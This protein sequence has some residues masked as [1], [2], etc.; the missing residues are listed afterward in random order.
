MSESIITLTAS[1]GE[2]VQFRDKIIA[3]GG[4]K[5]VYAS[6]DKTYV[7][8][9]YR[10]ELDDASRQRL[11]MITGPYR[12]R[13]FSEASGDYWHQMFCWPTATVEHEAVSVWWRHFIKTIFS[14]STVRSTT[15]CSRFAARTRKASGL[16]LRTISSS[17]WMSASEAIGCPISSYA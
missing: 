10:A 3:Q 14:L 1:N 17:F 12:E 16:P 15:T 5:D 11:Q 7:V 2:Q 6:P 13:I 4:M 9:F 8:A